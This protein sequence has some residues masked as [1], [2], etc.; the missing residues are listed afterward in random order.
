M[1]FEHD[2]GDFYTLLTLNGWYLIMW[3]RS[4]PFATFTEVTH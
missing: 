1:L 2:G 4:L 3:G